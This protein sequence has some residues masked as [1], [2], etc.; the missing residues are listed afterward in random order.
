MSDCDELSLLA[1]RAQYIVNAQASDVRDIRQVIDSMKQ[2]A[3]VMNAELEELLKEN[4]IRVQVA[5]LN[6]LPTREALQSYVLHPFVPYPYP[7]SSL[8]SNSA[9]FLGT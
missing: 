6:A 3:L 2:E 1:N 8:S 5:S 7:S 4:E 9:E